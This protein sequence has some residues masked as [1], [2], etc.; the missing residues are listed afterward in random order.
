MLLS[1]Y[2]YQGKERWSYDEQLLTVG[3]TLADLLRE[4]LRD[5]VSTIESRLTSEKIPSGLSSVAPI[6]VAQEVWASG[7]TYLRSRDARMAE[8]DIADVYDLVYDADRPELFLKALGWRVSGHEGPIRVRSDSDWDVPEPELVLV[9]NSQLE[10]VGFT[11][12]NDVSSRQIEGANPLYL[13]QAKVY[14]GSCAIGPGIVISDGS[15]KDF[16]GLP[17]SLN[18]SRG[19]TLVFNGETDTSQ[20]K[21]SFTELASHLGRELDFPD[22]VFLMTGT[23]IIPPDDFSLESGDS[24]EIKVG[25]LTLTNKVSS[26]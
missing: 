13:P 2:C 12:G 15:Q 10:I 25:Q 7:V 21:R 5:L 1:K 6:D 24:V 9:I 16:A 26:L 18:I 8:S 3:T 20:M 14:N 23:G 19:E 4:P 22:G 17:I 11:A